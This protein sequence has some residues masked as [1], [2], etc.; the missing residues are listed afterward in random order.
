MAGA[1]YRELRVWQ[2]S[3]ELVQRIYQT[4][5]R[6]PDGERYGLMSQAQRAAASIPANLAEG[7]TRGGGEYRY[8]VRVARGSLAEVEVY[9]ELFVKLGF[10]TCEEILESWKLSQEIGGML[11]RLYGALERD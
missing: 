1:G 2:A 10:C 7:H 11:T 4:T 5:K 8:H 3:M 9:L 6:L